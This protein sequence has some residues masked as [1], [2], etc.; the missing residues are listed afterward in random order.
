[1]ADALQWCG[2]RLL[3]IDMSCGTFGENVSQRFLAMPCTA[4][5]QCRLERVS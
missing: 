4:G 3:W 5:G 2:A 1:V